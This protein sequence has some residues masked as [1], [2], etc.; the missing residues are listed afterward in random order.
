MITLYLLI[1]IIIIAAI[2]FILFIVI[3]IEKAKME[4]EAE[5]KDLEAD[6]VRTKEDEITIALDSGVNELVKKP[7][8]INS[9]PDMAMQSKVE[10]IHQISLEETFE[11]SLFSYADFLQKN[12]KQIDDDDKETY[13]RLLL[14]N[15][16]IKV[17]EWEKVK[18]NLS[19]GKT[20]NGILDGFNKPTKTWI[21]KIN[22]S[23]K[24]K[25]SFKSVDG[26]LSEKN[27]AGDLFPIKGEQIEVKIISISGNII[28]LSDSKYKD[29]NDEE[30]NPY[31]SLL[32]D[33][34]E[35]GSY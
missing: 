3:N 12:D 28:N 7:I 20:F 11:N 27:I 29:S 10:D 23:L 14:P 18:E 21:V 13:L 24:G 17:D 35:I 22:S 15:K 25:K 19:V 31:V 8:N 6:A 26:F 30:A 34:V 2:A 32:Y 33:D 16:D 1:S 4:I 5:K 9:I